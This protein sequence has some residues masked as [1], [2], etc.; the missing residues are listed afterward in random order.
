VGDSVYLVSI[1]KICQPDDEKFEHPNGY[2]LTA[3]KLTS[4]MIE[5]GKKIVDADITLKFDNGYIVST[6]KN[7]SII[8]SS[9]LSN[10]GI[11]SYK[12]V[13]KDNMIVKA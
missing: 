2:F 7:P 4:T 11:K 6:L 3:R 1:G 10:N 8:N 12:N 9:A 5:K 13:S